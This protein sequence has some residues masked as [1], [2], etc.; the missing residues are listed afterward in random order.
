M[1]VI[2]DAYLAGVKTAL[3]SLGVKG[4]S[5][6][7]FVELLHNTPG[8]DDYSGKNK[9]QKKEPWGFKQVQWSAP[10]SQ[11]AGEFQTATGA[12]RYGGV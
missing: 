12:G 11:E 7:Q 10:Q 6:E 8:V 1:S 5:A 2:N 3:D 4:P 9:Q